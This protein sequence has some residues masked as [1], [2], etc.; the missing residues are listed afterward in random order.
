[1]SVPLFQYSRIIFQYSRI[2]FQ[3]AV[4]LQNLKK[5]FDA[6]SWP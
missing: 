4:W 2:I 6:I 3:L 5:I 1:M